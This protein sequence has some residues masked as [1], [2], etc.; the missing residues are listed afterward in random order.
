MFVCIIS[1]IYNINIIS[2]MI[3]VCVVISRNVCALTCLP[4]GGTYLQRFCA[5][6]WGFRSA[7]PVFLSLHS[8]DWLFHWLSH[9]LFHLMT[10]H[11]D[12]TESSPLSC[13]CSHERELQI[14]K[15]IRDLWQI[16][17]KAKHAPSYSQLIGNNANSVATCNINVDRAQVNVIAWN[18]VFSLIFLLLLL[19][20]VLTT[21]YNV[22]CVIYE[23]S[24][25]FE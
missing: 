7:F 18:Y 12:H 2:Y 9:L 24:D 5:H 11:Q 13:K 6:E 17:F 19:F 15:S 25:Q 14:W 22:A 4:P 10:S 3:L 16:F 20:F 1:Y 23:Y 8:F 21:K